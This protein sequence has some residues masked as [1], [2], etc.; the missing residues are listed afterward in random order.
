MT[1]RQIGE[2]TVT[3]G[4][5]WVV[6]RWPDGL[7][8]HAHPDGSTEQIHIARALGY[9]HD[10]NR[11]NAEH[12]LLHQLVA[13]ARGWPYS[14]TL[15]GVAEG[16]YVDRSISDDEERIVMLIARL[17]NVGLEGVLSDYAVVDQ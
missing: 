15:R 3:T 12:D 14:K 5:S 13:H 10:T 2:V 17:L 16:Q 6:S 7:E 1:T 9:G 8:V 4:P 11:M